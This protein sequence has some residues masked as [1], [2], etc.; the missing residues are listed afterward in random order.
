M[1]EIMIPWRVQL[2]TQTE[3]E[4][5]KRRQATAAAAAGVFWL[6]HNINTVKRRKPEEV[7]R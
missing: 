2:A 6:L 7:V 1:S 4:K 3:I 5:T